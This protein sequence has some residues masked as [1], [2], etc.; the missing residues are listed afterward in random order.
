MNKQ[1]RKWINRLV[2]WATYVLMFTGMIAAIRFLED[3]PPVDRL[4]DALS[5]SKFIGTLQNISILAIV[6]LYFK[7][8]P[9]RKKQAQYEAWRVIN[10]A[11]GQRASGGRIQALQ[12]L[13][14]DHESLA[15]LT[16]NKAYL[17]GI[18]LV[19][20]DLRDANLRGANL[21]HA[22]LRYADLR[23]ANL[24]QADL[25][26]ADLQEVNLRNATLQG[27]QTN[28]SYAHLQAAHLNY[29]NAQSA[30]LWSAN[31]Q[32]ANLSYANFQGTDL[33]YANLQDADLSYAD[34]QQADL[35]PVNFLR[36]KLQGAD[37]RGAD[38]RDAQNL[39]PEQVKLARNWEFALYDPAFQ[40]QLGLFFPTENADSPKPEATSE[41]ATTDPGLPPEY[42]NPPTDLLFPL[43]DQEEQEHN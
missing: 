6:I 13:N 17:A 35:S 16:A 21:R 2:E 1:R 37:L 34:F 7:E 4:V 42:A 9:A 33:S 41:Q 26:Y 30:Y 18:S 43:S 22:T 14:G 19:G 11:Y 40:L 27:E 3:K 23:Y 5:G 8:A 10:S 29:A 36:T 20:S 24:Q 28:L 38:L 39:C 31:L 25:R 32:G 12:D 15:G